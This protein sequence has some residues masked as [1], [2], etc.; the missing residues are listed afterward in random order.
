[1]AAVQDKNFY[2]LR[3]VSGQEYKVREQIERLMEQTDLGQY[4]STVFV[5]TERVIVQRAGGK[6]VVKERPSLPGYVIVEAILVGDVKYRLQ[7]IQGVIG[8]LGAGRGE[9]F[10]PEPMRRSEVE[11]LMRL[12]D[13][14]VESE[15]VYEISFVVGDVVRITEDAFAGCEARVVELVPDRQRVR[16]SVKLLGREVPV[17]LSYAQV[18]K[19]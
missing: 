11:R 8:F 5:P 16:L 19:E 17:E 7:T 9:K 1:M 13:A 6:K 4:V 3:A 2:I 12:E 15:G 10:E 18:V 14:E